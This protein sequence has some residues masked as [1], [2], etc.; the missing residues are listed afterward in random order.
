VTS[1]EGEKIMANEI[2]LKPTVRA[3]EK[4]IGQLKTVEKRTR[5]PEKQQLKLKIEKLVLLREIFIFECGRAYP[6]LPI[7]KKR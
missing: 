7:A 1:A 2:T 5:G 4:V 6:V 3:L